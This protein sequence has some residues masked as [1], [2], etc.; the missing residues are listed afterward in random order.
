MF[1]DVRNFSEFSQRH[2]PQYVINLINIY[3]DLQARIVEK[4]FGVVDKFMG[5]QIMGVFEGKNKA[6]NVFSAGVAIQ[7]AIHKLNER[8]KKEDREVL[9]V[10]IGINIGT[11][12]VGNIGSKDRLDYT[13]VGD[14]VN[15][16][17]RFCDVAKAGQ[18]ITSVESYKRFSNSYPATTL[19]SIQI[20]GREEPV[21]I[22]EIDYIQE[23]IV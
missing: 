19:D 23:V 20:K 12:V 10:G 4:N 2:R 17:S 3:L 14:V 18:I 11:A 5:D 15:M 6:D 8:R 9:T 21:A 22:C 7:K 13:V 1:A 16:A